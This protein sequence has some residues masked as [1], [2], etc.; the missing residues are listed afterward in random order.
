[1]FIDY[2]IFYEITV[3]IIVQTYKPIG[4]KWNLAHG[5]KTLRNTQLANKEYKEKKMLHRFGKL[6][7]EGFI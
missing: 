5:G 7:N 1:L 2:A 3:F 6:Q 4:N